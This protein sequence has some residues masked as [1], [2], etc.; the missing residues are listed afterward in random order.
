MALVDLLNKKVIKVPLKSKNK[1]DVLLELTTILAKAGK[2]KDIK[3]VVKALV[4]RENIGSTGLG[5]GIAIPH[6]KTE[7]VDELTVAVGISPKGIEFNAIDGELST[8]FFL[9]LAPPDQ[10]VQHVKTLS[11]IANIVKDY[12]FCES[13]LEA[14]KPNTVLDIFKNTI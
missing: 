11:E 4:E 7:L 9:I 10:S 3:S 12:S 1:S 13:L 6:A 5:S 14:K 8:I 2:F